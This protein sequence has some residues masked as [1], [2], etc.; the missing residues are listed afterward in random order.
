MQ[1]SLT[2]ADLER[3]VVRLVAH[4]L[5][6]GYVAKA[7]HMQ[8][9]GR[10][11]QRVEHCFTHIERKYYQSNKVVL[12]DHLNGDHMATLLYYFANTVWRETGD[13]ELPTRLFYLNKI[14]HGLDMF[15]SLA[16][17]EIFMLVHPVG[18]VLGNARYQDYL[19]VYQ[20][21]TVG[22]IADIYPQF[23]VGTILYSRASVLGNCKLGNDV[24]LAANSMI[25]DLDVPDMTVVLGQYPAQRFLDNGKS[26]RERC[27]DALNTDFSGRDVD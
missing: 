6:D 1:L 26:V 16:M 14:L 10:T 23:G 3:Y 24:V 12:F 22:A 18:T 27:F 19:V 5:P 15:Y 21:C 7:A 17:P 8:L 25:I 11:L 13:T 20:N 9:F 4:Y 2:P